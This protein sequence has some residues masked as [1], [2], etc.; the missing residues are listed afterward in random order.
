MIKF[1]RKIRQNMIKENKVSK[2]LLYAIGE[3][4]LVVI[5]ILIA[6]GV[7]NWNQEKKDHRLGDELLHRIHSDLVQDTLNFRN[8]ITN[9]NKLR[10]EIKEFLVILYSGIDSIEQVQKMSAIYDRA[11]D[12]VFY[13]ND[14]TYKGM[15]S[16]G[17]LGLIQNQELKD[18]IVKL[19]SDYDQKRALLS[20]IGQWMI[21][22][23][24]TEN[25]QTDF[26]LFNKDVSDIFTSNEMLNETD[27]AFMNTKEDPRFKMIVRAIS[28]TAFS[29]K[30]SNTYYLELISKCETVLEHIER[31]LKD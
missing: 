27:F 23:A 17:T 25:I 6:L 9:N 15:I 8:T 12:Q 28:A 29:Q 30:A 24:T 2:Y 3:I 26:F 31:E 14:N 22:I 4:I 13:V 11:L 5:G 7:N 20:G 10:D 1:F 16:S 19:Y 18:D 21:S